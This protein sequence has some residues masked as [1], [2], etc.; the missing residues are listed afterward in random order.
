[1]LEGASDPSHWISEIDSSRSLRRE[2]G[3]LADGDLVAGLGMK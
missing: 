3:A 1:V 2:Q